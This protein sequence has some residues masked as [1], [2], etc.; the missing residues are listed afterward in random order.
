MIIL[1]PVQTAVCPSRPDGAF[2]V[3]VAVHLSMT[4]LYLPPVLPFQT[5][6]SVPVH[7]AVPPQG[8][9]TSGAHPSPTVGPRIV[10]GGVLAPHDHFSTCP[11]TGT[12]LSGCAGSASGSPSVGAGIISAVGVQ[13]LVSIIEIEKNPTPDDHFSAGPHCRVRFSEKGRVHRGRS[14]PAVHAR[15]IS[16]A[17]VETTNI[18]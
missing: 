10:S 15:I 13:V 18:G 1:P 3:V 4:R 8:G 2:T 5:I 17:G 11:H 16:P 6:I 14:C 7:T 12:S 9:C